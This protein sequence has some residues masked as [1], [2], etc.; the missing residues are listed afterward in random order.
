[1]SARINKTTIRKFFFNTL[2]Q[3]LATPNSSVVSYLFQ[4][5]TAAARLHWLHHYPRL[6]RN[7]SNV[8]LNPCSKLMVLVVDELGLV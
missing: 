7:A 6:I 1:M 5:K 3:L 2:E 4:L 8:W